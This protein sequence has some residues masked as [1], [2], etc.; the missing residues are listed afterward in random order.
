L[1]KNAKDAVAVGLATSADVKGVY[2]L[3]IL[4]EILKAAGKPAVQG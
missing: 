4:N 1:K 3:K 2:D